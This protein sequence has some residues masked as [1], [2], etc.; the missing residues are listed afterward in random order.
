MF[1][2][3]DFSGCWYKIELKSDL[4]FVKEG[5]NKE[6]IKMCI[7]TFATSV[8]LTSINMKYFYIHCFRSA[9]ISGKCL[10]II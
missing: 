5:K 10:N 4:I 9:F 6:I 7:F 2:F 3:I 8:Q 1:S